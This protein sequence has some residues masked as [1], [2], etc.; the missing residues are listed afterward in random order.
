MIG[1][2]PAPRRRKESGRPG[3]LGLA[4]DGIGRRT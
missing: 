1:I 2:G 3:D 4:G